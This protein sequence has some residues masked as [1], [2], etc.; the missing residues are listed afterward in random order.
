MHLYFIRHGQSANNFLWRQTGSDKGRYPDPELTDLG[1][2]QAQHLADFL[3]GPGMNK[4]TKG[5]DPLETSG[6]CITHLYT[7]LMVRAVAT[8]TILAEVLKLPL[9]VWEDVHEESGIYIRDENTGEAKGLAGYNREYYETHYP[10]LLLPERLGAEGWWNRPF[11][12]EGLRPLRAQKFINELLERHG[13][14]E[15][16]VAV[17]SHG[18]FYN[19]F[20]RRLLNLPNQG[21]IWFAINNAAITRIDFVNNEIGLVYLNRI[22]F[23]PR[24]L[25]T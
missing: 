9:V 2:R 15:D 11:E 3:S 16:R 25:I 10:G 18:G 6:F 17:I 23:M 8:G 14:T 1:R 24:E 12:D 22:D 21:G 7:S 13:N 4:Q 5:Y 19:Q 20:M